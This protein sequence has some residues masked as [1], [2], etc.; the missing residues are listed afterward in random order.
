[1]VLRTFGSALVGVVLL[2]IAVV[3]V[4]AQ[5]EFVL[6]LPTD[7]T[8]PGPSDDW[9]PEALDIL[10]MMNRFDIGAPMIDRFN[11]AGG[12]FGRKVQALP[13][14]T[15]AIYNPND[16]VIKI[17]PQ[18]TGPNG[19]LTA[20]PNRDFVGTVTHEFWHAYY[21]QVVQAGY[22]PLTAQTMKDTAN[23]AAGVTLVKSDTGQ[24]VTGSAL[25]NPSD[26]ADEY[27]GAL[28][29]DLVGGARGY[30]SIKQRLDKGDINAEQAQ[31][32]LQG[33]IAYV[34]QEKIEAYEGAGE[35]VYEVQSSPPAALVDHLVLLLGLSFPLP[36]AQ[37]PQVVTVPA[38]NPVNHTPVVTRLT[39]ELLVPVTTYTVTA[40]D[41]SPADPTAA[42]DFSYEWKMS[43][44]QCGTP[45]V[46]WTQSGLSV[47]WSHS[48]AIPD[49][50]SH[51]GTDHDVTVSVT[52]INNKTGETVTCV[53]TGT[54]NRQI[55]NPGC[56]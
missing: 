33:T 15:L 35:Q 9:T 36:P 38:A 24:R 25:S 8:L 3:H 32:L 34:K 18:D 27:V 1:M 21:Q 46:P 39:A 29:N 22:D 2:L 53:M 6:P 10:A 51:T 37:P 56:I 23:W 44:E 13:S 31:K 41:P 16:M 17:R 28:I 50:C 12:H 4:R 43:G 40:Q 30:V 11:A 48:S 7:K 55:D 14:G 19:S 5:N 49:R 45:G 54:E 52:V 42:P 26:F 20:T 47:Q